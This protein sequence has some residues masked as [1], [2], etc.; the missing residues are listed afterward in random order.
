MS[1]GTTTELDRKRI[2]ELMERENRRLNERTDASRVYF[3]R[4]RTTLA[5]GVASDLD[6]AQAQ[7]QLYATQSQ[8]IELGVQRAQLEHAIAILTGRPPVMVT[9]VP[10]LLTAQPDSSSCRRRRANS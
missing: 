9:I 8:I 6:V 3:E 5:G 7:S 10:V 4:A 2:A 1:A